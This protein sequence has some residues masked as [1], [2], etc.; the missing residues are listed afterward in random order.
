MMLE[1]LLKPLPQRSSR[2]WV[3]LNF[4]EDIWEYNR[5]RQ[6]KAVCILKK[7]Y[8]DIGVH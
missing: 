4:I 1:F 6:W 2:L 3:R 7:K 8:K 5:I